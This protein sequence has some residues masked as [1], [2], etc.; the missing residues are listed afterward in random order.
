MTSEPRFVSVVVPTWNRA[1]VLADCLAALRAQ[2]YPRDRF[3]VI[4]VDDGSTDATPQIVRE[5]QGG[6]LPVLRYVRGDHRGPNASR[7]AGIRIA[8]G[9]PICLVD[10]DVEAPP[11]WLRELVAGALRHPEA[12]AVGGRIRVRFEGKAPRF[13][14]R[15]ALVGEAE[16][17]LG[18]AERAVAE[19]ISANMAVRVW[20]LQA[21]GM[22]DEAL[23]IYGDELEWEKRLARAGHAIVYVPSATLWHRR[24]GADLRLSS[25]FR[26][27]LRRGIG[28]VSFARRTGEALSLTST[29]TA[30]PPYLA[31]AVRRRCMM[32]LLMTVKQLGTAWGL[33]QERWRGAEGIRR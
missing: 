6:P 12:G 25:F 18:D 24:V 9:D 31:H 11:G 29:L 26:R 5:A 7:N 30:V 15:E 17:D 14:G 13:C 32:G 33:L 20:A 1:A 19:V 8:K 10:D 28:Y 27:Y 16:F 23:P 21:V 2:D 22:F 3:E 4:V